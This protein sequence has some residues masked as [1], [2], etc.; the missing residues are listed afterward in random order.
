M[1]HLHTNNKSERPNNDLP[2]HR[3]TTEPDLR[4]PRV[5]KE[6]AEQAFAGRLGGGGTFTLSPTTAADEK[7][8][9]DAFRETT[10]SALLSPSSFSSL[11]LWKLAFIEG[12][13]TAL[14]T[15]LSG[16]LGHGLVPTVTETSIGAVFPVAMA[17]LA[18]IFLI[19]LFIWGA[20]PVTGAH[21]NPLITIG[22]FCAKLSSLPRTVLYV[23]FQCLG[24]VVGAYLV[25][26][27]LGVGPEGL[28]VLPGCYVDPTLVTPG[29]A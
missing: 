8:S 26:A 16:V 11:F 19:S 2:L 3:S 17:S 1:A 7:K 9:P 13:G 5:S 24:A 4:R 20:G 22:T 27:S 21:F 6:I 10:W 12:V 18:Q 28:A 23:G 15:F 29:Q 25:R 14:Q